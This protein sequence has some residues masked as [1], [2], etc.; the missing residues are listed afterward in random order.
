[1]GTDQVVGT[2][3]TEVLVALIFTKSAIFALFGIGMALLFREGGQSIS[4]FVGAVILLCGACFAP[5]AMLKL[6][7]FAADSHMAG[8]MMGTLRGGMN[9][10]TS[11][12]PSPAT[13]H[14]SMGRH[15]MARQ[16]SNG[17]GGQ[18]G[19]QGAGGGGNGSSGRTAM[20]VPHAGGASP[21]GAS[22]APHPRR[23]PGA[24]PHRVLR[25]VPVPP[26]AWSWP[27][28]RRP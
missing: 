20:A 23:A 8:E 16:Y 26:V 17:S 2:K 3:A 6:V 7:H 24:A 27:A 12:I 21:T 5:L 19:G 18:S 10:V 11:R 14:Q 13:M 28:Q 22:S 1:M 4:D 9:P 25:R 15:E